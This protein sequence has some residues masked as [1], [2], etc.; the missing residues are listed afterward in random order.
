MLYLSNIFKV[1]A[2][3]TALMLCGPMYANDKTKIIN[4][5]AQKLTA[6][7]IADMFIGKTHKGKWYHKDKQG[8]WTAEFRKDGSKHL[9][10]D[11]KPFKIGRWTYNGKSKWCE[12]R[13]SKVVFSC[14]EPGIY[15]LRKTC[16]TF[17]P[18]GAKRTKWRC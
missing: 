14:Q 11:G 10:S 4:K 7:Q 17:H 9:V 3:A 15:K 12:T 1:S 18:D 13:T 6:S 16:Y 2:L 5:G 8:K